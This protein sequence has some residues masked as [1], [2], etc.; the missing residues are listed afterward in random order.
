MSFV[1][2]TRDPRMQWTTTNKRCYLSCLKTLDF[3][4]CHFFE[5]LRSSLLCGRLYSIKLYIHSKCELQHTFPLPQKTYL[6]L[7]LF[8]E[9]S[10]LV[11]FIDNRHNNI[12]ILDQN[13][14]DTLI[15]TFSLKDPP[16]DPE[17]LVWRV[18]C[19]IKRKFMK[20]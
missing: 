2:E 15:I 8:P 4:W 19:K 7:C 5:I 17:K 11:S 3:L 9:L 20:I 12:L 18:L 10:V 16:L 14:L 6:H 1:Q 13:W